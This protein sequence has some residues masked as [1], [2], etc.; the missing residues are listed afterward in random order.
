[1]PDGKKSNEE[2]AVQDAKKTVISYA[3]GWG[4][5]SFPSLLIVFKT[6]AIL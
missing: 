2:E 4:S 3:Q 5:K 1:M 6:E